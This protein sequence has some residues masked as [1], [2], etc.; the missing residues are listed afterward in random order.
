MFKFFKPRQ[1]KQNLPQTKPQYSLDDYRQLPARQNVP[2]HFDDGG[3]RLR[4]GNKV[5]D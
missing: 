1:N 2:P 5:T 3:S 4:R